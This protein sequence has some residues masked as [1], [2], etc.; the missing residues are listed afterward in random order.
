MKNC[1]Q[2]VWKKEWSTLHETVYYAVDCMA[3]TLKPCD[4]R[5]LHSYK[6]KQMK[7]MRLNLTLLRSNTGQW[8]NI[9]QKWLKP[10]LKIPLITKVKQILHA[11][12]Q[13]QFQCG[14]QTNQTTKAKSLLT[15]TREIISKHSQY[16]HYSWVEMLKQIPQLFTVYSN[17]TS[18]KGIHDINLSRLN[19]IICC[20]EGQK[21]E[22]VTASL[23]WVLSFERTCT[24]LNQSKIGLHCKASNGPISE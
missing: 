8:L 2:Q 4:F 24:K 14:V 16:W 5:H 10:H 1:Q 3:G 22:T 13:H 6:E 17:S 15:M 18:V 7:S 11:I 19:D 12:Y 20:Y 9:L 21:C 23:D